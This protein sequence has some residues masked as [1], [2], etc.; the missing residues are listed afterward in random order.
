MQIL[1]LVVVGLLLNFDNLTCVSS[2]G[3]FT[4][5]IPLQYF[6]AMVL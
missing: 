1:Y 6:S 4:I 3:I 2:Q 5:T